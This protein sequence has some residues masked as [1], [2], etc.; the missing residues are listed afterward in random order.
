MKK[1]SIAFF[2]LF[3]I[4]DCS[5]QLNFVPPVAINANGL[6]YYIND[7]LISSGVSSDYISFVGQQSQIAHF[8]S[9]GIAAGIPFESGIILSSGNAADV[10]TVGAFLSTDIP[11]G[12]TPS[13]LLPAPTPAC[14]PSPCPTPAP[15]PVYTDIVNFL[16]NDASG[17]YGE[18]NALGLYSGASFGPSS[19]HDEVILEFDFTP[20][21]P[22]MSFD[23]I[24]GSQ[25]Y[26]TWEYSSYNDIFGFYVSGPVPS[27][28]ATNYSNLN[29]AHVPNY[30]S[31]P[32]TIS[33]I[34]NDTPAM[35]SEY[36]NDNSG[37]AYGINGNGFTDLMTASLDV[38]PCSTY[39]IILAVSDCQDGILDTYVILRENSLQ[40][41]PDISVNLNI[42]GSNVTNNLIFE[43]CGNPVLHMEYDPNAPLAPTSATAQ[44]VWG[45]DPIAFDGTNSSTYDYSGI[46]AN[47]NN[48]PLPTTI[49][50]NTANPFID[51]TLGAINDGIIEGIETLSLEILTPVSGC[52]GLFNSQM[53]QIVIN[54]LSPLELA[55]DSLAIVHPIDF[56]TLYLA[57]NDLTPLPYDLI[58]GD[59]NYTFSWE[60]ETG[61]IATTSTLVYDGSILGE[62]SIS[63]TVEDGCNQVITD[64]LQVEF[65]H[66][67]F[68]VGNDFVGNC[69]DPHTVSPAVTS[70][71]PNINYQWYADGT[72]MFSNNQPNA[73]AISEILTFNDT[74]VVMVNGIDLCGQTWTDDMTFFIPD[75]PLDIVNIPDTSVCLY[76]NATF[77]A[78]ITGGGGGYV[79]EW[80]QLN[81][82]GANA[83][84][85]NV[86]GD[87]TQIV[88]AEDVCGSIAYDTVQIHMV[89][90][91]A[92]FEATE[93]EENIYEFASL[94]C[95]GC[96]Y[97][98]DMGDG[99]TSEDTLLIHEFDGLD[100]YTVS[101]NVVN[102]AGCTDNQE[103][104][105]TAPAYYYIPSGFTPNGDGINDAFGLVIE[106]VEMYEM[107]IFN[108]WGEVVFH[109]ND[110]K[111]AWIGDVNH[112]GSYYAPNGVY[113]YQLKI[114]GKNV[115]AKTINGNITIMR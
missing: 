26:G 65:P 55:F 82:N 92:N 110:P 68:S 11:P 112:S 6:N 52:A 74:T 77:T 93:L 113:S 22:T 2:F 36:Y 109:S 80:P 20:T 1:S 76:G 100:A 46:D 48:I 72:L 33:T 3:Y 16:L 24:F 53:Q 107:T 41:I 38:I 88:Q 18:L 31:L 81:V 59:A 14:Y 67:A 83:T 56:D 60:D 96:M 85:Y 71:T 104:T 105:V 51:I 86:L 101:L 50:L 61:A 91:S 84:V 73:T 15:A 62:G 5:A 70:G 23:Y 98:W 19:I 10:G 29:I 7:V 97:T 111:Q 30:P 49:T 25:E 87:V 75:A 57:C 89:P 17:V 64:E 54:D 106:N 99:F 115:D 27:N 32:I 40:S 102:A 66:L 34:N 9:G 42:N 94:P 44:I 63:L 8:T 103:F 108:R 13:P 4:L 95:E 39:H 45:G 114:K 28:P 12:F 58:G 90:V 43:E 79:I 78:Q 37:G 35:F 69:Q 21:G 47:Q